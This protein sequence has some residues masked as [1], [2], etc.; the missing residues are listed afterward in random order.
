[1]R[2]IEAVVRDKHSQS[3][4]HEPLR[5]GIGKAPQIDHSSYARLLGQVDLFKG[6]ERVTL[7]K[8]AAHLEPL[9][10]PSGSIIFRQAE[11]ADAFY[12]VARGAVGVYVTA[13]GTA[14]KPV[15]MLHDGAPFGEMALLTNSPRAATIKAETDCEVLR[16]DRSS[17]LDLVRDHPGVALSIAA[18]LSRRLAATPDQQDEWHFAAV[19][20]APPQANVGTAVLGRRGWRPGR[21]GLALLAALVILPLGWILPPPAGLSAAAWHALIVLSAALPALALDALLESVLAFLLA[22]AWVMFGVTTSAGALSGFASANWVFVVAALIIASAITSTGVLYRLAL[23]TIAHMRGGFAGEVA[24]LSLAGLLVGP[25]VP[26]T[27]GRVIMIAPMLKDLIEGLGYRPHSTAAAGLAMAALIGF[28]QMAATFLTSSM[29]A[30]MVLAVLPATA[31]QDV[32]WV[33]WALYAAPVNVVLFGG[34]LASILWLY[35]PAERPPSYKRAGSLALQRALLGPISREEKIAIAVGIGL[36]VGCMTEPLHGMDLP[37]IA[38]LAM[39]VLTATGLVT[40]NTLRSVNWNFALLYGVLISLAT[41]FSQTRLDG[42]I[43]DRISG[44]GGDLLG[45]PSMFV[46]VLALFCFAISLFIRWQAAAPLITIALTPV[47]SASGVHPFIVGL[48]AVIACNTFFLPYQS[49]SYL[50]LYTGTAGKVFTHHQVLPLALAYAAWTIIAI[51][52]SLPVWRLMG[53]MA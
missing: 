30:L 34:L 7:A 37:W 19:T 10:Y 31:R 28:G 20:H 2:W 43:A 51:V 15:K 48:I 3:E 49:T 41:V 12:L 50:A 52:L 11:P 1:L 29:T 14:E 16:L 26:N 5:E 21:R 42:W 8:L 9:S 32:N 24:A 6:L 27:T 47:A 4:Q 17:F 25:A 45:S 40:V 44:A 22:G 46:I 23:E 35:R 36:I 33:T 39:T 13:S 38:V 18:T 53:L